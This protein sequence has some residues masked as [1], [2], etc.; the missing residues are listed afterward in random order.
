MTIVRKSASEV[1]IDDNACGMGRSEETHCA[2]AGGLTQFGAH[3]ERL[4]PGARSSLRHWHEVEDEFVH[5]VSGEVVLVEDTES[6]LR[7]GDA[8]AW[9]AGSP[10]GHCL[11]NRGD[12]DAVFLVVGTR[13]PRDM[14]H[15]PDH[16]VV[17]T[18]DGAARSYAR[19]N[20]TPVG[21]DA[22]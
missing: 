1:E 8:A 21:G 4:P 5:V 13:G 10:V 20:G 3:L 22:R 15:Y 2:E 6:E 9:K 19:S 17:L 18:K 11:E 16:D 12:A 7:T 14:V